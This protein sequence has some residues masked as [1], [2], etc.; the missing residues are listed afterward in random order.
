MHFFDSLGAP[1]T[2][3]GLL[4]YIQFY[5]FSRKI[6][7]SFSALFSQLYFCSSRAGS[8]FGGVV[9]STL[10]GFAARSMYPAQSPYTSRMQGVSL[11]KICLAPQA[12]ASNGGMPNPSY[13]V[14]NKNALQWAIRLLASPSLT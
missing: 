8:A 3:G 1:F 13:S 6:P 2:Q 12:T 10:P 7:S 9:S 11:T 14:G 4:L 5:P